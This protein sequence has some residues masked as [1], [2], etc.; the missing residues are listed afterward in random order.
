[1]AKNKESAQE[2]ADRLEAAL[3]EVYGIADEADGSRQSM[4]AA[5]DE[6]TA[7]IEAAVPDAA[8]QWSEQSI[9]A[10]EDDDDADP[11]DEDED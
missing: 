7:S 6:I 5:L 10:P 1:V 3:V 4:T 2:K 9:A 11:S 8:D